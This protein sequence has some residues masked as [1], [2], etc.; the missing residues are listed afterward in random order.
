MDGLD[1][2]RHGNLTEDP[3]GSPGRGDDTTRDR[4]LLSLMYVYVRIYFF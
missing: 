1:V 2:D 4:V 3:F